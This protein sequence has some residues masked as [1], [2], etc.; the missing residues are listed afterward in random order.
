MLKFVV[1]VRRKSDWTHEELRD[2][3][4]RVH[5]QLAVKIPGLRHYKQNF[6]TPDTKRN[7]AMPASSLTT[8]AIASSRAGE[9]SSTAQLRMSYAMLSGIQ[10]PDQQSRSG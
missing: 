8:G 9:S 4:V 2:Y 7:N 3:F 10:N 1:V 6:P 5:G